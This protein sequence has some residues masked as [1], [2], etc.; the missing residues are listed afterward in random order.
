MKE[1]SSRQVRMN[2]LQAGSPEAGHLIIDSVGLASSVGP[3]LNEMSI[4]HHGLVECSHLGDLCLSWWELI[5]EDNSS[6][7]GCNGP[8]ALGRCSVLL[9]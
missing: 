9:G 6:T 4:I 1:K 2:K 5:A 7:R 3:N 8:T